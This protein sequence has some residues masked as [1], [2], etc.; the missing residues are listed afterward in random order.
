[1]SKK[2]DI[3][4]LSIFVWIII[5]LMFV[6]IPEL[7][8]SFI[9]PILGIPMILF[10]PG[11]VL[12]ATLFPR[13]N[14][15]EVI[16]RI[17]LS[18]GMSIAVVP[19]LGLLLNFTPF[20]IRL[21][22]I[23]VT[24]GLYTIILIFVAAYRRGKLPEEERFSVQFS[25]IY[26]IINS[27]TNSP[28]N[29]IDSALTIILIFTIILAIGMVFYVVATP[30]IG[31]RF[32][33]FYI[34]GSDGKADKYPTELT[35]NTPTDILVGVVNHQY[36][37]V[38]YTLRTELDKSVLTSEKILLDNNETWKKNISFTPDKKGIDMRLEFLLFKENNL[39]SP[40]RELH[41]WVNTT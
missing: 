7:K 24:L 2:I 11:Y 23:L 1:M 15:I 10:I 29:R 30:K 20:G 26:D 41:L 6:I 39:T 3:D 17:A 37:P 21:I 25:G 35:L 14:D 36:L 16:E 22:P 18:F 31:E 5:T 28:K 27:G 8:D 13:K 32:T 12:V 4:L 9:R 34:L 38:N 33:E 40:Y 19:L